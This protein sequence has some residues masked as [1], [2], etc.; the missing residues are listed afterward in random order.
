MGGASNNF[1]KNSN[2]VRVEFAA[3]WYFGV[4]ATLFLWQSRAVNRS[5]CETDEQ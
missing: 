5:S 3:L 4:T 1:H 2:D